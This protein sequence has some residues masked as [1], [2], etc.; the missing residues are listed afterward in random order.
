MFT[1][2]GYSM[3]GARVLCKARS[4]RGPAVMIRFKCGDCV[5]VLPNSGHIQWA[6]MANMHNRL[7]PFV[8]MQ[9]ERLPQSDYPKREN[10]RG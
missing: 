10:Q 1:R 5:W 3:S 8:I 9:W 4:W 2:A 7:R 6:E